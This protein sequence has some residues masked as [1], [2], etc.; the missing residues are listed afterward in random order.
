[1]EVIEGSKDETFIYKEIFKSNNLD[2]ARNSYLSFSN[3]SITFKNTFHHKQTP[4]LYLMSSLYGKFEIKEI[5]N[6]LRSKN[7][8][9]PYP[10]YQFQLYD[11]KKQPALF[12]LD[13]HD[14]LF[15]WQG[16][17]ESLIELNAA[18]SATSKVKNP[19]ILNELNAAEGSTRIRFSQNRKCAL[20][21]A[22]TYWNLK[23]SNDY[24]KLNNFRGYVVYAGLEPIQFT[25]L[26]P[27]WNVNE[28]A[29]NCNLSDGKTDGQMD[30]IQELLGQ[31][32]Q[33]CY[34]LA[35][36]RQRPLPDG[37]NPLKLEYYLSDQEFQVK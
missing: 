37:V 28:N 6:P 34:P 13:N 36:L 11:E 22:I 24:E 9:S 31:L 23:H 3:E 1:M 14:E 17:Y 2:E 16:W 19:I 5:F 8:F 10:F 29:R 33:S 21:T 15:I 30:Q 26:F 27:F 35:V 18:E 32:N 4:R 25:Y 7:A 20:Q 12:M